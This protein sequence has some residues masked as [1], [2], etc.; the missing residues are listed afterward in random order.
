MMVWKMFLLFQGCILRFH[1]NL[2][3][4]KVKTNCSRIGGAEFQFLMSLRIMT[5]YFWDT[6]KF[7]ILC[8]WGEYFDGGSWGYCGVPKETPLHPPTHSFRDNNLCFGIQGATLGNQL[9]TMGTRT[10]GVRYPTIVPLESTIQASA[11]I[12]P[13]LAMAWPTAGHCC[14]PWTDGP[15]GLGWTK[16]HL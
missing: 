7:P 15:V 12:W 13:A 11:K 14:S 5:L 16:T 1:V 2:A 9:N 3:R 8:F 10:L 6:R 4:C